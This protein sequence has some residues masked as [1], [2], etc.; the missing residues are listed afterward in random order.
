MT[1]VESMLS[2]AKEMVEAAGRKA[3]NLTDLAKMKLKL[4]DNEK[5]IDTTLAALGRLVYESR[6]NGDLNEET[7]NELVQQ[8]DELEAANEELQAAIDNNRGRKTC[9]SCGS[10]NP[11]NAAYCNKCG[12]KME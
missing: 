1:S 7:V 2:K 9:R 5:A 6:K 8:V 12:Q 4:A 10:A 3:G 11:E